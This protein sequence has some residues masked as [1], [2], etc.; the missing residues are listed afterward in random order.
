MRR[1]S[2]AIAVIAVIAAAYGL[3]RYHPQSQTGTRLGH[4]LYYVD[5]M[6]PS[7]KS[8]RPGVAPDCGM[9]LVPVLA[10]DVAKEP[11]SLPAQLPVGMVS[12][13]GATRRLL[14]IRLAEVERGAASQAIRVVGR[15]VPEDTRVYKVNAGVEGFI[16]QTFDDS[17][18]LLV[19]KDQRLATY[20]AW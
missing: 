8:E 5:P 15:V 2:L 11:S 4:V 17:V 20:Y 3:G 12:I 16:R 7:Y 10:E 18:G 6:H 14:G 9:Q 1:M 19:K 13:D